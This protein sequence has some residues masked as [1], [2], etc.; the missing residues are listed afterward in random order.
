MSDLLAADEM[1]GGSRRRGSLVCPEEAGAALGE[2]SSRVWRSDLL[3]YPPGHFGA[4][5]DLISPWTFWEK[6]I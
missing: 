3:R 1:R 4:D 2:A 6:E 5:G